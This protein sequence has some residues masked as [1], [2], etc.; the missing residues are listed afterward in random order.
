MKI[1]MTLSIRMKQPVHQIAIFSLLTLLLN[2]REF[3]FLSHTYQQG[4][5]T[6][7]FFPNGVSEFDIA[8]TSGGLHASDGATTP[9]RGARAPAIVSPPARDKSAFCQHPL[10]VTMCRPWDLERRL[11]LHLHRLLL[12]LQ[13]ADR[14]TKTLGSPID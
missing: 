11:Q 4:L 13:Q 9:P 8:P 2:L 1:Y 5:L 10:F 6:D 3:Q 14:F 7:Q 12:Y